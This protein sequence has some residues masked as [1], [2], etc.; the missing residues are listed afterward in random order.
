MPKKDPAQYGEPLTEQERA[1]EE[2]VD[3]GWG[4]GRIAGHL[5]ISKSTVQN[6]WKRIK[7]KR[8]LD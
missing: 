3:K 8:G 7:V 2:L 6:H 1:I 5:R 4:Q